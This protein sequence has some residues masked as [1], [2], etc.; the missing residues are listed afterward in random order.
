M[1]SFLSTCIVSNLPIESGAPV[2]FLALTRNAHRADNEYC[3]YVT[4]RWQL[5]SPPIRAKYNDYGSVED[6]AAGL[7]SHVFFESLSRNCIEKGVGDNTCHDVQVR[8]G[9]NTKQWL[10]ALWEGRVFVADREPFPMPKDWTPPEPKPGMPSMRRI[11]AVLKSADLHTATDFGAKG[12]FIDEVA[13]GFIRVRTDIHDEG[14]AS[15]RKLDKIIPLLHAAGYAAMITCGTGNYY[16]EHVEVLVGPR[17]APKGE[18]FH[19]RG[20]AKDED[21][22]RGKPRPVAQA[23]IREDVWQILLKTPIE[24]YQST[25]TFEDMLS[26]AR[27]VVQ[28][29]L[30]WKA[31]DAAFSARD[32]STITKEDRD[33]HWRKEFRRGVR[34][35]G[36]EPNMLR[37]AI[38]EGEGVSGF[39][40]K[41]SLKLA[42]ALDDTP[43]NLDAFLAD[44]AETAYVQW[45]YAGLH[46]QWH[47]TTN[48]GQR[49]Q[50]KEHRAFLTSLLTI[51]GRWEDEMEESDE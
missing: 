25:T 34:E 40:L 22:P 4:G 48:N 29:E 43:E 5:R 39:S 15:L 18:H 1:G 12:F 31:E 7:T 11:E 41:Q 9:M 21:S 14:A 23:M 49:P 19:T 27:Q 33:A 2:R 36:G 28:E 45:V 6:I 24:G 42:L 35:D 10:E 26:A 30:A 51:K 50:W 20:L 16:S 46:G 8:A 37:E 3:C 32:P 17:P 44:L 13:H 38:R 47:L